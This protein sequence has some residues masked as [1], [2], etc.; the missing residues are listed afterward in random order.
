MAA[1]KGTQTEKNLL[2]AFA[3]ESQ[4]RNRYTYYASKAKK[5][6]Y[7]QISDIFAETADQEKE[8]AKRL[9]KLL[10][11]GEVEISGAFPAGTI[12]PTV[13]NLKAAAAGENYEHTEM[14]PGFAK[15]A[16]EEGFS[17]IAT[18][19]LAIAVA[20]KQH[21]KRYLDLAANIDAS[22]VFNR[23]TP[24]VWRC[25]NCGYLHEGNEAPETCPACDH[26][27]A[28][29]ELLGENW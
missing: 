8:H 19:F 9:F 22:R 23:E 6:G 18:I 16:E 15:V 13:E 24:V 2:T 27:Q 17:D 5:E 4:A 20:E 7:V 14:Y 25:R 26:P 12:D 28:H 3:G 21:E 11:G 1:L 29:F 10:E